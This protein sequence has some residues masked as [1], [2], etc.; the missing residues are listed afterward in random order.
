MRSR[1][2]WRGLCMQTSASR[3]RATQTRGGGQYNDE[4]WKKDSKGH[5]QVRQPHATMLCEWLASVKGH[6]SPWLE[7][8]S[9]WMDGWMND[10]CTFQEMF[11]ATQSPTMS[12]SYGSCCVPDALS[13]GQSD[14]HN[15]SMTQDLLLLLLLSSVYKWENQRPKEAK[16]STQIH[17][18][19]KLNLPTVVLSQY[20]TPD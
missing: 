13:V 15:L 3:Q 20:D 14:S 2:L 4:A 12:N 16:W 9:E 5:S 6:L 17:R 11:S 19:E 8:W 7:L 1:W 18:V 10:G